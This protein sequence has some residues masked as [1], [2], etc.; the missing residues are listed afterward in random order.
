MRFHFSPNLFVLYFSFFISL[1]LGVW[2]IKNRK[3][4]AALQFGLSMLCLTLWTFGFILELAGI[5]FKTKLIW[6]NFQFLFIYLF[7]V[8]LFWMTKDLSNLWLKEKLE[9]FYFYIF[10]S[11]SL[12]IFLTGVINPHDSLFMKNLSIIENNGYT[13]LAGAAGPVYYIGIGYVFFFVILSVGI[14]LYELIKREKFFKLQ[15]LLLLLAQVFP[16]ITSVLYTFKLLDTSFNY[17][18][19]IFSLSGI[20]I[21]IALFKLKLFGIQ[22]IA[23][24]ILI[25]NLSDGVLVLDRENTVIDM[26]II[27][28]KIF[29]L[30]DSCIGKKMGSV[31]YDFP[32]F[33][34]SIGINVAL[35]DEMPI[36]EKFYDIRITPIN[37]F[38][39]IFLGRLIVLRDITERKSFEKEIVKAKEE[40]EYANEA[41]SR[42]LANMSHEIRTPLNGIIGYLSLLST[43]ELSVSQ[44]E[45]VQNARL[46]SNILMEI[47]N[48]I[49]DISKIE[50]GKIELEKTDFSLDELIDEIQVMFTPKVEEKGLLFSIKKEFQPKNTFI[51]DTLRIKQILINLINNAVKF[52]SNGSIVL[53]VH[54]F[55]PEDGKYRLHFEVT[56]T[57]IGMTHE[58]REKIFSPFT[59]ADNSTTRKYG[60][61]GLGLSIA[62]SLVELMHGKIWVH[63]TPNEGSVFMFDILLAA[64]EKTGLHSTSKKNYMN[65]LYDFKHTVKILLAEDNTINQGLMKNIFE[66]SGLQYSIVGDG[67]SAVEKCKAESFDLIFMDIQMPIM[68][69][70]QASQKIRECEKMK[71]SGPVPIIALTASASSKET[72]S[73]VNYGISD[74]L[75]KPFE[76]PDFYMILFKYIKDA[77]YE[78]RPLQKNEKIHSNE[79]EKAIDYIAENIVFDRAEAEKLFQN[80]INEAETII[81][82]MREC[83]KKNDYETL[84]KLAHKLKGSSGFFKLDAIV[85]MCLDLR[86]YSKQKNAEQA[87]FILKNLTGKILSIK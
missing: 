12:I 67:L 75:T 42:F 16:L 44:K 70:C 32:L 39:N 7:P 81:E 8:N 24:N 15:I 1:F 41:K 79:T 52:T 62:K 36:G 85:T 60:G 46:S 18:T 38:K 5:D 65:N 20:L 82:N 64:S 83:L 80:Y 66:L 84:D 28:K 33:L 54:V 21:F 13:F 76:L 61:T 50:A 59:Q 34:E 55:E 22:P 87:D 72:K 58:Q 30:N 11:I 69:G 56:D 74:F 23:K 40:A 77:Q 43:T 25:E 57:G 73:F 31:F 10:I 37:D 14:L 45:F 4:P 48:N 51:G 68:D 71:G 6:Y 3:K 27:T 17:S 78:L 29:G 47:I 2:G 53:Y 19:F 26:N 49:L 9:R 35:S 63:S 86:E